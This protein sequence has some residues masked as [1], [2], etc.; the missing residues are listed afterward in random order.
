MP[1]APSPQYKYPD[2]NPPGLRNPGEM[3]MEYEDVKIKTEDGLILHGWFIKQ[4]SSLSHPTVVFFH[5]N[6]GN[7]G[8]RIPYLKMLYE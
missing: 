6:A 2:N 8:M 5:E 7:I 1:E 3:Q 4:K